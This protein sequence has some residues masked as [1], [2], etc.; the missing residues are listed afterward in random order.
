[1]NHMMQQLCC[2]KIKS[3]RQQVNKNELIYIPVILTRCIN[4]LMSRTNAARQEVLRGSQHGGC[5][6]LFRVVQGILL[7]LSYGKRASTYSQAAAPWRHMHTMTVLNKTWLPVIAHC[8]KC[9]QLEQLN[10]CV[11]MIDT[12]QQ[13]CYNKIRIK[14][15]NLQGII[16]L[17]S[18]ITT[19]CTNSLI[20]RASAARWGLFRESSMDRQTRSVQ[21]SKA[22]AP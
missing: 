7:F 3:N 4:N 2:Y 17:Y 16:N 20:N 18:G 8:A 12:V 21:C 6:G 11:P 5:L 19:R 1:M 9:G 13:L 14:S 10:G 15:R 22:A